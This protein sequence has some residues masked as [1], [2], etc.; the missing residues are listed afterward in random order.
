MFLFLDR[1]MM[2]GCWAVR[3]WVPPPIP[4]P[5]HLQGCL[6]RVNVYWLGK[7]SPCQASASTLSSAGLLQFPW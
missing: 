1:E 4:S 5:P 6:V 3:K 7:S 2:C